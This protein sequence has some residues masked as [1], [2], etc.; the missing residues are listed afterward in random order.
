[1]VPISV[2]MPRTAP[3]LLAAPEPLIEQALVD[4]AI[5]FCER[6]LVVQ[7]VL[8]PVRTRKGV[9]EYDLDLEQDTTLASVIWVSYAGRKLTNVVQQAQENANAYYPADP[10]AV[11]TPTQAHVFNDTLRLYPAP[12]VDGGE[13]VVR[14]AV[15][16]VRNAR[17]F[18]DE[19]YADWVE[20]VSSGAV[21]RL[22]VIP[23]ESFTNPE[24]A[25]AMLGRF[26]KGVSEAKARAST[27]RMRG[28]L[29]VR[30]MPFV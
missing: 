1:M 23:G 6:T 22:A 26:E 15:R 21:A 17:Q 2:F 20:V 4:S 13:L 19:L 30:M 29:R 28:N 5:E 14:V 3:M 8:E 24:L 9:P 25:A 11:S 10:S 16:P 27:G 7:R 18:P 12:D